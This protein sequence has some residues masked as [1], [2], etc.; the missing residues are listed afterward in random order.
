MFYRL[1]RSRSFNV[2]LVFSILAAILIVPSTAEAGILG[3]VLSAVKPFAK[4]AGKIAGAV[5][6]ATL[7]SAFLPPLGMIAG[8]IGGWIVGGIVTGYGTGSLS[9]LATLGG[10]AAGAMALASFGPM[11]YVAGALAGGFLGRKAMS[12]LHSADREATGGILFF[13]NKNKNSGSSTVVG[14]SPA[15]A[16]EIPQAH[17]QVSAPAPVSEETSQATVITTQD[18]IRE[19]E[20]R[21]RNA[22]NDYIAATRNNKAEEIKKAHEKYIAAFEAYK[23]LTGEEPEK[24]K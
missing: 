7:G 23:E 1:S 2:L 14:G 6:G 10:A 18:E 13:N 15:L 21:Y 3:S 12:L 17:D 16:P 4:F 11:G 24:V 5:A 9:N 20:A 8:G 19:A 22:Y